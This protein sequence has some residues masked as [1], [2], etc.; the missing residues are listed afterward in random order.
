[1]SKQNYNQKNHGHEYYRKQAIFEVMKHP[2]GA[3]WGYLEYCKDR[4]MVV[5]SVVTSIFA[6]QQTSQII[7][8]PI[9]EM[10]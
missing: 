6:N 10:R 4:H 9:N 5:G 8:L 3:D 1:M 7:K 2:E